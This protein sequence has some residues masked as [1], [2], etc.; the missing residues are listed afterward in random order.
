MDPPCYGNHSF[1]THSDRIWKAK[2]KGYVFTCLLPTCL[3]GC[4]V[5]EVHTALL[6]L[7]SA[8][9]SLAG[10]VIC[11]AEATRRLFVPG[12]VRPNLSG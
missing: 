1:W 4:H 7:V 10:E 6:M 11:L 5:P 9:R 12:L 2:H 3:Y 8:L